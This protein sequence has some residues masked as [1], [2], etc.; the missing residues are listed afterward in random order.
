[1]ENRNAV[2]LAEDEILLDENLDFDAL[3]AQLQSELAEDIAEVEFLE[4]ERNK[5]GN[6][7][8]LGDVVMNVV[9]EQ[10]NK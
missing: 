3:E 1:M 8:A 4:E 2:M 5:I 6:P 10:F 9:V 7:T